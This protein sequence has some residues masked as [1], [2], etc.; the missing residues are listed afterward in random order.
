MHDPH[1]AF[2]IV[3]AAKAVSHVGKPVFMH[4]AGQECHHQKADRGG[5]KGRQAGHGGK[6]EGRAAKC[7]DDK[8]DQRE[9]P[10]RGGEIRRP[11]VREPVPAGRNPAQQQESGDAVRHRGLACGPVAAA[12]SCFLADTGLGKGRHAVMRGQRGAHDQCRDGGAARFA[13]PHPQIKDWLF[14]KRRG[15]SDMARFR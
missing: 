4:G 12:W 10:C 2:D 6:A 15:K 9:R 5:G 13:K 1:P 11:V 14:A 3:P 7:A 8:P